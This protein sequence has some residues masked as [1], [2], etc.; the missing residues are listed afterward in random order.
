MTLALRQADWL[1]QARVIAYARVL[2]AFELVLFLVCIAGTYGLIV[3]LKHPTTSDFVSFY[4]AG[5]LA[6]SAAPWLVYNRAAHFAAEQAATARGIAYSQFYYPPVYL[7]VCGLLAR[8]PYLAAFIVFQATTL[9]L[10]LIAVRVILPRVPVSVLLAFPPV[11]WTMGTGQNAFLSAALLAGATTQ[12]ERRPVIS[13]L[14]IGALCYKPHLGLLIPVA[15][16]AG[17]HWRTYAAAA[18]SVAVLVLLSLAG[19]GWPTWHAF[20]LEAQ[21]AGAVYA[22]PGAVDVAGYTSP[23]GMLMTFGVPPFV[24]GVLQGGVVAGSAVLVWIVWRRTTDI[25]LRSMMLLAATQVA[26]PVL[27]F[28][29]LMVLGV[30]MA[31]MVH[32]GLRDGFGPWEKLSLACLFFI[33]LLSGNLNLGPHVVVGAVVALFGMLL[34]CVIVRRSLVASIRY[35]GDTR[36]ATRRLALANSMTAVP[37]A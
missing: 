12:L 10:C 22:A 5:H 1:N 4:A 6:N 27:M 7:L 20:L 34:A 24:A 33:P 36:S 3:P 35:G 14:L 29:D 23:F 18:A 37:E 2:L 17:G 30:A 8:L 19:F 11:F 13:G 21:G 28:Y 26:V 31:W 9:L 15:L 32:R 16:A 25:A